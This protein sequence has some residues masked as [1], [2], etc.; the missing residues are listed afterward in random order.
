M[1]LNIRKNAQ[2]LTSFV[3]EPIQKLLIG[4]E[5][6][7]SLNFLNQP[8]ND[9]IGSKIIPFTETFFLLIRTRLYLFWPFKHH[10]CDSIREIRNLQYDI[11][12]HLKKFIYKVI[13]AYYL[14]ITKI[15]T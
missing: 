14:H 3:I 13:D 11:S 7:S 15:R 8:V 4:A 5:S 2:N 10:T 9:I 12:D 6:K 1:L